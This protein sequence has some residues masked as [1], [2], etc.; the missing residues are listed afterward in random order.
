M[1]LVEELSEEDMVFIVQFGKFVQEHIF[2]PVPF[3]ITSPGWI[4]K[5]NEY[6]ATSF[7]NALEQQNVVVEFSNLPIGRLRYLIL[8]A[9]NFELFKRKWLMLFQCLLQILAISLVFLLW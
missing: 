4:N 8:Y 2:V 6:H 9:I 1:S 5:V 7:M 3:F